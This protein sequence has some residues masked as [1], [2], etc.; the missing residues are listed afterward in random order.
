MTTSSNDTSLNALKDLA[1]QVVER[2][3]KHGA[4]AAEAFVERSRQASASVRNGEIEKLTEAA[5]KGLGLRV[6]HEGRLGF[7]STTDFSTGAIDELVSR[8]VALAQA[9]APDEAN[10]LPSAE[11]LSLQNRPRVERLFDPAVAELDPGWKLKTAYALERAAREEDS[12]C[13][14][15]EG[16]GAGESVSEY[17][18]AS[19]E[20]LV[21]AERG[22]FV[23]LWCAPVAKDGESFQTAYW[24]DYRRH[25]GELDDAEAVGREA[26]R[27]TVR[28]LGARKIPTCRVP[29][30][31]DPQMAASFFGG[32]TGAVNGDMV[33]KRASF[34]ADKLGQRIAAT[35]VTLVD[36]ATI[37]GALSSGAFDGEGVPTARLPIIE[38]GVL[39]AFLYDTR[40]AQKAG[41]RSTGHAQRGYSSLPSIGPSNLLVQPGTMSPE[42][43]LKPIQR[44]LYVTSMLGRGA[45]TVTGDYSRG[46]SGLWIENGQLTY[47]VQEV[48]VAGPLLDMLQAIDAVG[49]D[50]TMRG[51]I[52]APTIRFA[53]LAVAGG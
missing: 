48:T 2:A 53:E 28:M 10:V 32:L 1:Q 20:G 19:T 3:R 9:A 17:A 11:R 27:R 40:T 16:S 31:F 33:F 39:Q 35:G 46:A 24:S 29:V 4:T 23:Y 30:V 41:T 45:N 42:E 51:S 52:G 36:D 18:L 5:S 6:I 22:T 12:R 13:D 44:G 37:P 49:S 21:D 38:N 43:I 34:L 47:P 14:N 25:L 15:F 8:A 7:A 26:A 50:L